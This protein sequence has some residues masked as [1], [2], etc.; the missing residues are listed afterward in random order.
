MALSPF[1]L[2]ICRSL[3][4][5]RAPERVPQSYLAGGATLN[6]LLDTPRLSR[7]LDLF[8][9]TLEALD[10]TWQ[11]D[12]ILLAGAGYGVEVL[13]ER[14]GFV[15]VTVTRGEQ[16]VLLQW[17][18]DSAFRF[19]PLLPHADLGLTLHPF[20]LAT[21]KILALVGR[22]EARDWVDAL[23][24]H[25]HV[26]PLG[27]LAWAACGKDEGWNPQLILEEAARNGRASPLEWAQL[28]WQGTAPNPVEFKTQ[29]R[30]ALAFAA[31]IIQILPLETVGMAVLDATG[32]P[33]QGDV[34][35]LQGALDRDELRFHA[36]FVGGA[37]PTLK[38]N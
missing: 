13:R 9:D 29:W 4:S 37:W 22:V 8:H 17:V 25:R 5:R 38:D 27:L 1:Q 23:E 14:P 32:A 36:G 35:A 21:N 19:F 6:A 24:C 10:A 2:E 12:Q 28:E 30:Q 34:A 26:S 7:D 3:A 16:S 20:D 11:A 18:R 15:E 33:F 31:E